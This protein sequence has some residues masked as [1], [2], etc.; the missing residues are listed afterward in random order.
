M[1]GFSWPQVFT[2]AAGVIVAA[3]VIGLVSRRA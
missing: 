2:I 3:V 1:S